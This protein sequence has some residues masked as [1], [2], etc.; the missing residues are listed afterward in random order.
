[1]LLNT[2]SAENIID[3]LDSVTWYNGLAEEIAHWKEPGYFD[4]RYGHLSWRWMQFSK[5]PLDVKNQ[6]EVIWMI[7]VELF[8]ECG[9]SPRSGW[10]EQKEPF[11]QFVDAIT[12]T[13]REYCEREGKG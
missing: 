5:F 2:L 13:H 8:G 7:C 6:L 9:T 12:K 3:A 4:E 10:I 11:Y 1:M